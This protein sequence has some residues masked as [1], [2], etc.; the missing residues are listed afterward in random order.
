MSDGQVSVARQF[1]ETYAAG[2][3]DALLA[4]LA[5]GWVLH[6]EDGSTTSRSDL[7]DITRVHA[8][9]FPEKKIEWVHELVDGKRV[10][11]Y[12]R[13]TLVH[14]GRYHDLEPTGRQVELWEMIFHLFANGLIAESWRM[15]HPDGVY[16]ALADKQRGASID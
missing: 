5:D 14:S 4:C 3:A 13:F 10:T 1:M 6:E 11:H 15:T 9:A 12:V 8:N 7:A 16:A 2:D